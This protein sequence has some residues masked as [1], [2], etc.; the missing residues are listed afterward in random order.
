[1]GNEDESDLPKLSAPTRGALA[2]AGYSNLEQIAQAN[3]L[4][5][6]RLH[7]MAQRRSMRAQGAR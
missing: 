2:D 3:E 1:M 4:D 5:L 6:R 7:G